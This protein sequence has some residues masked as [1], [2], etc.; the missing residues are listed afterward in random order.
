MIVAT[1]TL[2]AN[3]AEQN[4]FED[5]QIT[6]KAGE[7]DVE[8]RVLRHERVR[9]DAHSGQ[10]AE[11]LQINGGT[12]SKVYFSHDISP[13]RIIPE[14]TP[15]VWVKANR[16][17]IQLMARVVLPHTVDPRSGQPVA[18]IIQGESY[19]KPGAWQ[20]LRITDTPQLLTRQLRV[21]Q[22][23]LGG[24]VDAREAYIDSLVLNTF[25]GPGQTAILIDD[26]QIAG[27]VPVNQAVQTTWTSSDSGTNR[28]PVMPASASDGSAR[29]VSLSGSMLLVDDRPWFPRI[30]QWQGESLEWLKA[31][32]FNTVRSSG[33]LSA[34]TLVE[35]RHLGLWL[36]APP[37]I[38]ENASG[39]PAAIAEIS[40]DYDVVLAWH[41]GERLAGRELQPVAQTVRQLRTADRAFSRP[42]L[43]HVEEEQ[44]SYSRHVNILSAYRMPLG[45]SLELLDYSAWLRQQS[46]VALPG[47][48][49]WS[50]V[51]T[52]PSRALTEQIAAFKG[53]SSVPV[54]VDADSVRLLTYQAILSG[55]RGLEFASQSRLDAGDPATRVRALSLALLN[56]EIELLEPW[57]AGGH[58]AAQATCRNPAVQGTVFQAD[59]AR[60]LVGVR[61]PTGSQFV[62]APHE[63]GE[64]FVVPG[65]PD[66]AHKAHE[67]TPG[68]L[69]PLRATPI[70][71]GTAVVVEDLPLT[72]LVLLTGDA[73]A[74][75]K[76][77]RRTAE[78]APRAA[79]L[80]RAL[81]VAMLAE[82]EQLAARFAA[83]PEAAPSATVLA[84]ARAAIARA[85][86]LFA[87]ANFSGAY[88]A[89]RNAT[90]PLGRWKRETWQ[91]LVAA[92]DS[93]IS[94]P[95]AANFATI[96]DY[97]MF[98]ASQTTP[99]GGNLLSGGGFEDL[100]SMLTAGWRHFEHPHAQV[101]TDV[102]LS[103]LAPYSEN[104]SLRLQARPV[105]PAN[106]PAVIESPPLWITSPTIRLEAGDIV[107]IRGQTRVSEKITGSVDGLMIIDSLGGE[108]LASRIDVSRGW[109][110]FVCYRAAPHAG[111]M[112][113][114][115]ALTGMGDVWIDDVSVRLV[116]SAVPRPAPNIAQ[117]MINPHST[118]S[119]PAAP[120]A[121]PTWNGRT[122]ALPTPEKPLF[123]PP[124][125]R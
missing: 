117:E 6:W 119:T 77:Q 41:L 37:P 21:L 19:S 36:I 33:P 50:V 28:N 16:P 104:F 114:T 121:A 4:G 47:T 101:K 76:I 98:R 43:A 44:R 26:L 95:L 20:Q 105:D 109:R 110:E 5:Q 57:I 64:T 78:M 106:P 88:L 125:L 87:T 73:V 89:A 31:Q 32:G 9:G 63:Y 3:G 54:S 15:S 42:I 94:N 84:K 93:P 14:L 81:A 118:P 112:A 13:S 55:V 17:G 7:S 10:G 80:Q 79:Q 124:Q 61:C 102:E 24:Q 108:T 53:Q 96:P 68:G 59:S 49:I 71:G 25:G 85:D 123:G 27:H 48:P 113:I 52:E 74:F 122:A 51:Q 8:Y 83:I 116:R 23:Q 2:N 91:R 111:D 30:A 67:L 45:T 99:P 82:T 69:R 62:A 72:S 38:Q 107:C 29:R 40:S 120:L 90:I 22:Y 92:Q 34:Q 58:V 35:A 115:F 86:Q 46:Q 39:E 60:L 97:L 18:T 1:A 100:Q 70:A 65:M 103:P 66:G 75:S 56:L 11:Y 12:G